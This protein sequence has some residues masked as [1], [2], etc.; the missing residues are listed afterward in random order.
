MRDFSLP[1]AMVYV[2]S[3]ALPTETLSQ[4]RARVNPPKDRRIRISLRGPV[5]KSIQRNRKV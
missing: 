2:E 3:D 4:Y 5:V 1:V